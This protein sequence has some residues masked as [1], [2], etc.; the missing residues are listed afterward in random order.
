MQ[1]KILLLSGLSL[2]LA[3][4]AFADM[5]IRGERTSFYERNKPEPLGFNYTFLEASYLYTQI[6][7]TNSA[8][9]SVQSIGTKIS[10]QATQHY[11]ISFAALG[12]AVSQS[13]NFIE[14]T[15]LHLGV[16]YHLDLTKD[17]DGYIEFNGIGIN[18]DDPN[19]NN[20]SVTLS[21]SSLTFGI[22]QRIDDTMEW[23]VSAAGVNI[24]GN[25][26]VKTRLNFSYGADDETQYIVA[27][28]SINTDNTTTALFLGI[29]FNY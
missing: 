26:N 29:R 15:E 20:D 25:S 4:S 28:E 16:N 12:S 9:D 27:Y 22:R 1:K 10:F 3:N 5:D 14:A 17:T 2:L 8:N 6:D 18:F 23:G 24:D 7:N 19:N 21:G 13:N 11:S